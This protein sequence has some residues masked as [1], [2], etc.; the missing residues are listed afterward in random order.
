[1]PTSARPRIDTVFDDVLERAL[2]SQE[3]SRALHGRPVP[4]DL[5]A[6]ATAARERITTMAAPEYQDYLEAKEEAAEGD[7]PNSRSGGGVLPLLAVFVPSL[8][9]VAAAVFLIA[10]YALGA[11][12]GTRHIGEGLITAGLVAAVVAVGAVIVDLIWLFGVA[13]RDRAT[14][15]EEGPGET[16]P[17][18]RRALEL[19]EEALLERGMLPFLLGHLEQGESGRGP[20]EPRESDEAGRAARPARRLGFSSP[21]FA[22]PDFASPDFAS[23]DFASPDFTGPEHPRLG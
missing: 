6:A 14:A 2:A 16:A 5:K 17:E 7:D 19:W 21:D 18:V 12:S 15:G 11:L 10:G 13:A 3:V 23:P 4:D 20:A 22:S 8:S 1:M 9:V